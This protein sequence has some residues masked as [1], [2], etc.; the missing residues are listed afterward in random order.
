MHIFRIIH[1]PSRQYSIFMRFE[2]CRRQRKSQ[3]STHWTKALA[4]ERR[5][6]RVGHHLELFLS[7]IIFYSYFICG[8]VTQLGIWKI[9]PNG[10]KHN[11]KCKMMH[12]TEW[13]WA[14]HFYFLFYSI[15][16][17]THFQT[18]SRWYHRVSS[19]HPKIIIIITHIWLLRHFF[20]EFKVAYRGNNLNTTCRYLDDGRV[21]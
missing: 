3:S 5:E 9:V 4:D 18:I 8:C 10:T 6:C 1:N 16:W 15:E 13:I 11:Y 21:P 2:P 20:L 14:D 7:G 19:K 17:P 12:S